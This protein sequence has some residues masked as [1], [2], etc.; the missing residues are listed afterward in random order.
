MN[1]AQWLTIVGVVVGLIGALAGAVA[2]ARSNFA[3]AQLEALRGDR[4]D[5]A[6]RI[7][8]LEEDLATERAAR[9]ADNERYEQDRAKWEAALAAEQEKVRILESVVTG[10]E[11]IDALRGQVVEYHSAVLGG[12]RGV[13]SR[14]DTVAEG[15]ETLVAR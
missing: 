6:K 5:Q 3:K 15:V 10:K 14:L 2:I 12:L 13:N 8:R 4:D 7:D 1:A 11:Q 9:A